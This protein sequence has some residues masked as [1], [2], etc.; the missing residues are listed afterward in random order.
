VRFWARLAVEGLVLEIRQAALDKLFQL[1]LKRGDTMLLEL[2]EERSLASHG[3]YF[4]ILGKAWQSL[5]E[6][7]ATDFPSAEHLR[8]WA[9]IKSGFCTEVQTVCE[10]REEARRLAHYAK[11]VD[12]FCL[13]R[14]DGPVVTTYHALTQSMEKMNKADFQA[15][16]DAVFDVVSKILGCSVT[17]LG[18]A[19]E[20]AERG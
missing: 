17:E 16:K 2:D 11:Q 15:S 10:S 13:T 1:K 5:P 12:E 6:D 8:K 20:N 19:T 7:M 18:R 14:I 3:H 4:A 9:L